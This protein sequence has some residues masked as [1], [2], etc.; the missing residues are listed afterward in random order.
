MMGKKLNIINSIWKS[1]ETGE[2]IFAQN[3]FLFRCQR[4]IVT[5]PTPMDIEGEGQN[6]R[7]L[8]PA[9]LNQGNSFIAPFTGHK[10]KAIEYYI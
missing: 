5:S 6:I 9:N 1:I 3:W 2:M 7:I 4:F 8:D 10:A